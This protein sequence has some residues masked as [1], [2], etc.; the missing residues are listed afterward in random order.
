[1]NGT[2]LPRAAKLMQLHSAPTGRQLIARGVSPVVLNFY[3][4]TRGS[5]PCLLTTAA[6]RLKFPLRMTFTDYYSS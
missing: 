3:T 5:R 1:M 2:L 6:L 4:L